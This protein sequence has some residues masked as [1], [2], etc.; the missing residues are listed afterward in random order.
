MAQVFDHFFLLKMPEKRPFLLSSLRSLSFRAVCM[1]IGR[2]MSDSNDTDGRG[3][4]GGAILRAV[5]FEEVVD[6]FLA[7]GSPRRVVETNL[8]SLG[9]VG[10]LT[11]TYKKKYKYKLDPK[12]TAFLSGIIFLPIGTDWN[13][14]S[15]IGSPYPFLSVG[16]LS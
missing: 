15:V 5:N 10:F 14:P 12:G 13:V 7:S 1:D 2:S 4:G 6:S 11:S 3:G 9:D 16:K 8:P